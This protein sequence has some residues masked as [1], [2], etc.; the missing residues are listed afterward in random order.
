MRLDV[1]SERVRQVLHEHFEPAPNEEIGFWAFLGD[2]GSWEWESDG[3]ALPDV[4]AD[5]AGIKKDVAYDVAEVLSGAYSYPI[6]KY[7]EDDPY[8]IEAL[9]RERG[10]S[11][12]GYRDIWAAFREEIVSCSRSLSANAE[13]ML[14]NIFGD[15]STH[16]TVGDRRVVRDIGP[17]DPD[18]FF[19]RGRQSKSSE[20][21]DKM[22]KYPVQ[23]LGPPPPRVAKPGRMN[24]QGISVFYGA[25]D[26]TTCLAELRAPV[27]SYVVMAKF[28]LLK[29]VRL[30]DLKALE[31][32]YVEEIHFDPDYLDRQ[33]RAAFLRR[34][35]RE[36]SRP[37]MPGDEDVD[38]LP[39]QVV[40][41]YLSSKANS[42]LDGMLYPSS[43]AGEE[44]Q[45][46]V[47][48][49]HACGVEPNDLPKGSNVEVDIHR[50]DE[51][52]Q[53]VTIEVFETPPNDDVL[54][55]GTDDGAGSS[56]NLVPEDAHHDDAG[57]A[58]NPTLRLDMDSVVVLKINGVMYDYVGRPV[59][60]TRFERSSAE[61]VDPRYTQEGDDFTGSSLDADDYIRSLLC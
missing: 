18:R 51:G 8:S 2:E 15:L 55:D 46:L 22:L 31:N 47:L 24:A 10:P 4:V 52:R 44:G 56:E 1:L 39:T 13:S 53:I 6:V 34:L 57:S 9:Y 59:E 41:E 61:V 38:Y 32:L 35:A 58:G 5:M 48:F 49:N 11:D 16:Q 33:G 40:A 26:K 23:E 21:L 17:D 27:G 14:S 37:V 50:I 20:E 19:W 28:E 45:N 54:L 3:I 36:F 30:L 12:E 7:G 29:P 60:R 42:P 43:Q 25:K